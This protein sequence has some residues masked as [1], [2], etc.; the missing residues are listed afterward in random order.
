MSPALADLPLRKVEQALVKAAFVHIR[1]KGSH[2]S[3][4]AEFQRPL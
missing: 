1:T 4:V 2:A 3:T